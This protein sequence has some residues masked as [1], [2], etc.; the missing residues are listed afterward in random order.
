MNSDT[1]PDSATTSIGPQLQSPHPA[2]SWRESKWLAF[3]EFAIV[4]L[5]FFLDWRHL[6]PISKTPFLLLLAWV[7]MR[8]RGVRWRDLGFARYRSWPLTL[9]LGIV[10]GAVAETFQLLVTQPLLVRFTGKQPDLSDFRALTG[11][12]KWTLIALAFTWTLAAFG[13]EL[14]WR[15]YLMNRV[16]GLGNRTRFAWIVSLLVVN[17]VF[18]F[19]HSNQG[20]TGIAEE[21]IAGVLL[22]LIYLGTGR[23]LAVPIVA[24]GIQDT[25]DMVLIFFGKFPGM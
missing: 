17:A 20:V 9:T 10:A 8:L 13:E 2:P 6:I 16:A 24:H 25:T 4:G 14:V 22:G 5:I 7:S 15:G 12:V 21:G 11:N 19:A 18:G 3:C 1:R 23:N